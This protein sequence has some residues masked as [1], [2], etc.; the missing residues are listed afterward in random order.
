[1]MDR[2]AKSALKLFGAKSAD[3]TESLTDADYGRIY[4]TELKAFTDYL[5]F[6][7]YDHDDRVFEFDDGASVAAVFE[8]YPLD[9]DGKPIA[10]LAQLEKDLRRAL[11]IIPERTDNPWI[12]QLYLQDE[13][14]QTLITQIR[15]YAKPQARNSKHAQTWFKIL[16]EHVRDMSQP[17]GLFA[18]DKTGNDYGGRVR[19]V[20]L[21]LYRQFMRSQYIKGGKPAKGIESP[22][23]ELNQV[24]I[25]F[26]RSLKS[27][28]IK[29]HRY[30]RSDLVAWLFPWFSPSPNGFDDAYAYLNK[31]PF[32]GDEDDDIGAG[33]DL[34]SS[35][36]VS[37]PQNDSDGTFFFTGE[38]QR[39][40]SLKAIDTKPPH[41][42]LTADQKVGTEVVPAIWNQMPPGSIWAMT[43]VIQSQ[44][45]VKAHCHRMIKAGKSGSFEAEL[46]SAQSEQVQAV[47]AHERSRKLFPMMAGVYVRAPSKEALE[48]RVTEAIASLQSGGFT[49]IEPPLDDIATNQFLRNLPMAYSHMH[50][51][52]MGNAK[53]SRLTFTHHISRIMPL[54]GRGTGSG[55]PGA[56]LFN[57]V[58]EPMMFDPYS[59]KDRTKTAHGLLFGPTGAGKS[60]TLC[61]FIL[62]WMAMFAFRFFII[63]KGNSF[64]LVGEYLKSMGYDVNHVRFQ[65]GK[66]PILPPYGETTKALEQLDGQDENASD[67][68]VEDTLVDDNENDEVEES[69]DDEQ[70]DYLGEME[71]STFLMITG[72]EEEEAKRVTRPDR[73]VI[74][75]ALIRA[76]RRSRDE[77]KPH[78]RPQDVADE[79]TQLANEEADTIRSAR[80]KD[81]A[82]A[83][84]LWT[85]GLHG[86]IFNRYGQAWPEC[87]VTIIDMGILTNDN[88]KDMLAV[89]MISLINTMTGIGEKY[90]FDDRETVVITDEGHALTT[91]PL[92]VKPMVFGVKT[93]RKLGMWLLQATQN[94]EDYPD[95]AKKMLNLAEWWYLLVMPE[96]EINDLKRFK[97]LCDEELELLSQ[98]R[99]EPGKYTEGVVLSDNIRSLFRVVMPALPLALSMTDQ[100]EKADRRKRMTE[101]KCTEVDAA[102]DVAKEIR[103]NRLCRK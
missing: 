88:N 59:K 22:A 37:Y 50:D 28:G 76:L 79:L 15:A 41:G 72:A 73:F 19:R 5:N 2:L 92:L 26:M 87:D 46:A 34:A 66:T 20:R 21:C 51:Q 8:L 56:M 53:R 103:S 25:R 47:M 83:L 16:D 31:R 65:T 14:I 29:S 45:Q 89:A 35:L 81:M 102:F 94:L 6:C 93:W 62:H 23:V 63:E 18:E 4:R 52:K 1:M 99:K 90:Q 68:F 64:G 77:G 7:S 96:E 55:R 67:A 95:V 71:L 32:P 100:D 38:A 12:I 40:I 78:A 57:R 30:T 43:I 9:V 42:V 36:L 10:T 86:E 3:G 97:R 39:F 13:P 58:G 44:E 84:Y 11:A 27:A 80:I 61:Y 82:S 54:Y 75:Q 24:A 91:N 70:R 17:N 74:R 101:K 33:F 48:L 49:P 69:E 60:A 98:A 85:T